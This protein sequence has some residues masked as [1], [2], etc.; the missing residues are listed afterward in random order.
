MHRLANIKPPSTRFSKHTNF[1]R[2]SMPLRNLPRTCLI[3]SPQH[4]EFTASSV[5]FTL[6]HATSS[7]GESI[8]PVVYNYTTSC[9][10]LFSA[11]VLSSI[12]NHQEV[13]YRNRWPIALAKPP[14]IAF[15]LRS[16]EFGCTV[17]IIREIVA[18]DMMLCEGGGFAG[19][20]CWHRQHL[21][22][23]L[24]ARPWI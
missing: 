17:L 9:S 22:P 7:I 12:R 18:L 16:P 20:W 15:E 13:E 11:G 3:H 5:S 21:L 1:S 23:K 19:G 8:A 2:T 4:I 6:N 10:R 14:S 24:M